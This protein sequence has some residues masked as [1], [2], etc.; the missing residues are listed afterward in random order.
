MP[1]E[2]SVSSHLACGCGT[3]SSMRS[4]HFIPFALSSLLMTV[5]CSSDDPDDGNPQPGS[6]GAVGTGGV[7]GTGGSVIATGGTVNG[8]GGAGAATGTGGAGAATATGGSFP[9][10]TDTFYAT[11]EEAGLSFGIGVYDFNDKSGSTFMTTAVDGKVCTSGTAQQVVDL[12][13]D[14]MLEYSAIYGGGATVRENVV[15]LRAAIS[16]N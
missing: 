12:D 1:K 13:G 5:A 3:P 9:E 6:G 8:T 11:A 7:V 2:N 10:D 4:S 14:G 16:G 15:G